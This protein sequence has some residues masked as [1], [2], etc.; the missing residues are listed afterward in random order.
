MSAVQRV[1]EHDCC[2]M[3]EAMRRLIEGTCCL[4]GEENL[5]AWDLFGKLYMAFL[6]H[7]DFEEAH[8]LGKLHEAER[9]QH[10]AEHMRLRGLIE[11]ARWEFECA[12][13][14]SFREILRE[15]TIELKAHHEHDPEFSETAEVTNDQ[16]LLRIVERS[17]SSFL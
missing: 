15:L 11:R 13:G 6:E 1:M 7:V 2:L 16:N 8:I 9:I 12:E 5:C 17:E 14:T 10:Q 3:F 4:Q